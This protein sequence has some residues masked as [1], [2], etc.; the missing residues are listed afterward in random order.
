MSATEAAIAVIDIGGTHI[1]L[2]LAAAAGGGSPPSLQTSAERLSAADPVAVLR[3]LVTELLARSQARPAAIVVGVPGFMDAA[4]RRVVDTPNIPSLRG[5]PL[6]DALGAACGLPA[7]LEHDVA[8]QARGEHRAG[9]AQGHRLVLGVYFGTGIGA[10]FLRDGRPLV[11]GPFSMQLGHIPVPGTGRRCAC[12][13]LDCIEP[14]ACGRTLEELA[15]HAGLPVGDLFAVAGDAALASQ[16][17]AFIEH[18]AIAVATPIMLLDPDIAVIGGGIVAMCGYPFERLAAAIERR[19]SP[20]RPRS[21]TLLVPA[22]L[23][24]PAALHG[25]RGVVADAEEGIVQ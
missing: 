3:D 8:L 24:W 12:G 14:Y 1:R 11:G 25:A 9:A 17:D 6:A 16:L 13:G 18:Q 15:R 21:K 23:G 7:W 4:R 19:L 5:L 22:A 20:V 2:G 10:A